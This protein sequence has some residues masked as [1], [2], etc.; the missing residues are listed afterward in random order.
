MNAD[1]YCAVVCGHMQ[2][3]FEYS[4][5]CTRFATVGE[6]AAQA[7]PLLVLPRQTRRRKRWQSRGSAVAA[8]VPILVGPAL[9]ALARAPAAELREKAGSLPAAQSF[10]TR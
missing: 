1:S 5:M 8:A 4:S 10:N 6:Q 7:L 9:R 3:G 2:L